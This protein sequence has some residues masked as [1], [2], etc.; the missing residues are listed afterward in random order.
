MFLIWNLDY[1]KPPSLFG[2]WTWTE[3]AILFIW[4]LDLDYISHLQSGD[5]SG[6]GGGSCAQ[7]LKKPN[8]I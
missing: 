7:N 1:I 6:T 8:Q 3:K 4:N 5:E 2:T